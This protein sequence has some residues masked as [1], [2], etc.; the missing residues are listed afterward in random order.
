MQTPI[1]LPNRPFSVE[2][3]SRIMLPD[4]IF[5]TAIAV[6]E[7]TCHCKNTSAQPLDD[8][9]IYFE[10]ASD[11]AINVTAQTHHI[12]R[13]EPGA[14]VKVAWRAG[15]TGASPGKKLISVVSKAAGMEIARSIKQIFVSETSYDAS[16]EAWTC[17]VEEG[18]MRVTRLEAIT[19]DAPWRHCDD[20]TRGPIGPWIPTRMTMTFHP[21]PAYGGQH[22]DLPFSDP[23][24]KILA[25]IVAALAAITAIIAAVLGY[26]TAGVAIGGEFDETTLDVDCCAPD[27]G[28][29]GTTIGGP[30]A[31]IT[32]AGVASMVAIVAVAVALADDADPWWRGQAATAPSPGELTVA[33]TVDATFEYPEAPN[34]GTP[35]PVNVRW[36]YERATTGQTYTHDVSETRHNTHLAG[37]VEVDVPKE[38]VAFKEPLVVRARIRKADVNELYSGAELHVFAIVRSP[39]GFGF[40]IDLHDDGIAPDQRPND[41]TYTGSLVLE[42]A[43]RTLLRGGQPLRGVW[44][45]HI[46]AQDVN[47]APEGEV[48]HVA[49]QTIGG[50]V[51]ASAVTLT[52]DSSLPCPLEAMA[53]TIVV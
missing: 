26:G 8:V 14:A 33:E 48:P 12:G 34:A 5:D 24:W 51:V 42:E 38:I 44:T 23:W 41:G 30:S 3:L 25:W 40:V 19:A 4:G 49:A 2:P 15:F 18:E 47:D 10:S 21:N 9:T 20:R 6:Q 37:S 27:I 22:G 11:P 52:F 29:T 43:Y 28:G 16:T 31:G 13:L 36:Q 17:R 50:F 53:S 39:G 1:A 7:I 35:Y 32:V 46:F 45:V